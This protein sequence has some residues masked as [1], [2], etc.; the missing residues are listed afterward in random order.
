MSEITGGDQPHTIAQ[1][2]T[3]VN[4]LFNGRSGQEENLAEAI[5]KA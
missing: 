4:N 1:K 2:Q 3:P 5:V